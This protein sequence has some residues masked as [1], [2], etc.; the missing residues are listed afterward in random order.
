MPLVYEELR[1]TARRYLERERVD[2]TLQATALVH[3]AYLQLVGQKTATWENRAHFFGVAAQ[4]MRR[5]LV[6]HARSRG[7]EKRG[8]DQEKLS[9]NEALDFSDERTVDL[10]AL[11]D[12]LKDL[13][14]FDPLQSEIVEMRFFGGLTN[15]EIGEFLHISTSTIKREW[16]LARA[17]LRLEILG[18]GAANAADG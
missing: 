6:D 8:G 5:I 1:R 13:A 9:F 15:E 14:S 4:L 12:A 17:W 7:A 3:E 10:V 11:D 18:E 16:C 2:H